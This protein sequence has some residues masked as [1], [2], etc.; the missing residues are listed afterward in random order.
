[1]DRIEAEKKEAERLAKAPTK[2]KLH[3]WVDSFE[4]ADSPLKEANPRVHEIVQKFEAFKLWAKKEI[5]K[6]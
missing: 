5:E 1:L 2:E 6:L 4:I 3:V